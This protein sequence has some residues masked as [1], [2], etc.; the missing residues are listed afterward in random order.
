[1][2]RGEIYW[3]DFEPRKGSEQGGVRPALVIQNDIGN[4]FSPTTI[5]AIITRTNK[6]YP[7]MVE[8]D[9]SESG[10]PDRSVINCAQ[11]RTISVDPD[12]RRILP[13]RG[14]EAIRPIGRLSASKL[15]EV[16]RALHQSLGLNCPPTAS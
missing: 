14:E 1:M 5:V 6:A 8:I 11:I 3:V 16:D 10:L 9:P 4:R 12:D 15:A 2:E 7:F 13:P